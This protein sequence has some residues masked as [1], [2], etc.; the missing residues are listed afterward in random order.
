[1]QAKILAVCLGA[2]VVLLDTAD[3]SAAVLCASSSGVVRVR[4]NCHQSE[5]QL[6]PDALGLRGS[7]GEPGIEGPAG[8]AGAPGVDGSQGA[9]GPQGN[10]G[11]QGAVGPQGIEGPAGPEGAAGS[12]GDGRTLGNLTAI[13]FQVSG[14]ATTVVYTVPEGARFILTG[15]SSANSLNVYRGTALG[16]FRVIMNA[17][18]GETTLSPRFPDGVPFESGEG[19]AIYPYGTN[20]TGILVGYLIPDTQP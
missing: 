5:S 3:A 13:D 7:Q 14:A 17:N 19:V 9:A 11:D 12:S 6:D 8:A 2:L 1:M 16:D 10:Q 18:N 20:L 4:V 15:V